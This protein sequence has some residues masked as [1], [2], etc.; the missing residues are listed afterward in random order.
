MFEM[1][2]TKILVSSLLALVMATS[3]LA[4]DSDDSSTT[5]AGGNTTNAPASTTA[6]QTTASTTT[7]APGVTTETPSTDD[8]TT[9]TYPRELAD[10]ENW[11]GFW[12]EVSEGRF[13]CDSTDGNDNFAVL[14]VGKFESGK[15]KY[16]VSVKYEWDCLR[17]CGVM[18]AAYDFDDNGWIEDTGDMY[19]LILAN[20]YIAHD[21]RGTDGW[22]GVWELCDINALGIEDGD[23][24]KLTVVIDTDTGIIEGYLNDTF[25]G[26]W[27]VDLTGFGTWVGICSKNVGAEYWDIEFS[28]E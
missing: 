12:S 27:A 5:T 28:A 17:G 15:N 11:G 18:F 25:A 3:M 23:I 16:T 26:T 20:G 9:P 14:P 21:Y 19:H 8:P 24:V 6:K 13:S 2:F 1:K 22:A 4:C 10:D 7:V